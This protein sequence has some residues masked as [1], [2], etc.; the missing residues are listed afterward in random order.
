M[1]KSGKSVSMVS[2]KKVLSVKIDPDK[3]DSIKAKADIAK[4]PMA[5]VILRGL[6]ADTK[7]DYL[8]SQNEELQKRLDD[9]ERRIESITGRKSGKSRRLTVTIPDSLFI[10][11]DEAAH[12]A[13]MSKSEFVR[14]L[15]SG[16]S[17]KPL[18]A[19]MG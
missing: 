15:F 9:M 10:Q 3:Y 11:L 14:A 17:G 13:K 16:K 6:D 1:G 18:P 7:N 19:L 5:D 2:Q 12:K 8:K 4:V